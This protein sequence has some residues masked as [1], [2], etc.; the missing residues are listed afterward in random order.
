VRRTAAALG[1]LGAAL[2]LLPL[3]CRREEPRPRNVIFILVD[4]L[5]ADHLGVYGYPRPTSPNLDAF[6]RDAVVFRQAR[7]QASCTYPSVNSIL[8]SRY[9]APFLGQPGQALGIPA[10][11][12]S[13]AEVLQARGYDTVAVSAS[14]VVR[15]SPS[16]F[17]PGG[18][19]GRGFALFHE[20]CVWKSAACVNREAFAHLRPQSEKPL[21]LYLHYLDPHG[22]YAPP[23]GFRGPFSGAPGAARTDKSFIRAGNPNPIGDWLYK[24]APD[25]GLTPADRQALIDRYDDEIAFFDSELA[26]LLARIREAGLLED[27]ILVIAADHGEE[28]LEHGHV[29]HCRNL[30]DTS[31]HTPL[32]MRIPGVSPGEVAAP[33]ENVDIVPTLLD[34]LGIETVG[35]V[36]EGKSLRPL[37][38]KGD[39]PKG[40]ERRQFASQGPWRSVS[41]GRYKLIHDLAAGQFA[42]YDLAADPGEKRDVLRAER[43]TFHRLREDLTAWLGRAEGQWAASESVKRGDEAEKKLRSLG[44]LE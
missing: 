40:N 28:F 30:F 32:L 7:S 37:L 20:D 25:P 33:V 21:F 44:Y 6:A 31:T 1:L 16:R 29:K 15:Q 4:T 36:M 5:R 8:T 3:G 10:A 38:E 11:I 22:P 2:A 23:S 35:L 19:F 34:Y 13:I 18:G 9:P 14:A 39:D 24:G 41:D 27:S 17:N 26:R 12:P 42:L 43:R